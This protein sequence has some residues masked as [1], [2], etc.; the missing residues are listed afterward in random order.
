MSS[1]SGISS[2]SLIVTQL[3]PQTV[4]PETPAVP[5]QTVQPVVKD[6]DGDN[7]ASKTGGI[8]IRV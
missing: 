4:K 6:S 2:S 7:D 5:V 3:K 1:I 8:D